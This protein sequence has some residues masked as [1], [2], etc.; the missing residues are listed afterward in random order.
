LI[1]WN[2]SSSHHL[3]YFQNLVNQA[4][5]KVDISKTQR[6]QN[7]NEVEQR[8]SLPDISLSKRDKNELHNLGNSLSK[9][10]SYEGMFAEDQFRSLTN[11]RDENV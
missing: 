5:E 6:K 3:L 8:S 9:T 1:N 10:S 4:N 2:L 11:V 7:E